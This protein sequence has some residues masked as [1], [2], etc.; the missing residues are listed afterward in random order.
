MNIKEPVYASFKGRVAAAFVRQASANQE[1]RPVFNACNTETYAAGDVL[2]RL[3]G[4]DSTYKVTHIGFIYGTDATPTGLNTPARTDTW[5][6]VA[7]EIAAASGELN[8]QLVPITMAPSYTASGANYTGNV[9]TFTAQSNSGAALAFTPGGDY[10]AALDT[11]HYF[12]HAVLL[13][14][15]GD[16]YVPFARVSLAVDGAFPQKPAGW[17]LAVFWG[18]TFS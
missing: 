15:Q 11:G 9:V 13:S 10:A 3:L 2:A 17:D 1:L 6:S 12:Y 5:D 16:T 7:A 4:G 14:K 18:V 8:M